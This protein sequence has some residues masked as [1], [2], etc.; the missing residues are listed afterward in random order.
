[1]SL[2]FVSGKIGAGKSYRGMVNIRDEILHG[3]RLIV[4]NLPLKL[5]EFSDYLAEHFPSHDVC[6]Y[7]HWRPATDFECPAGAGVFAPGLVGKMVDGVALVFVPSRIR[8]L[9]DDELKEFYRYRQTGTELVAK[10]NQRAPGDKGPSHPVCLDFSPWGAKGRF[11]GQGVVYHLDECQLFYN[12]RKY[13]EA[14]EEMPFYLSQH[15]KLGDDIYVYTQKPENVDKMLRS[16]T[17]EFIYVTNVGKK[18]IGIFQPPKFFRM[19]AYP[20]VFTGAPGQASEWSRSFRMDLRLADCYETAKGIGIEA[21]KADKEAV[22][23]G[24]SWRWALLLPVLLAALF[25]A[26]GMISKHAVHKFFGQSVDALAAVQHPDK[27]CG[28]RDGG[29]GCARGRK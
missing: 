21:M 17:Q 18:K 7:D 28:R 13:A 16:F 20:D 4:T 3:H 25:P 5:P 10:I 9:G 24:I 15:R 22:A 26:Y 2:Y 11:A 29:A 6:L 12:V 19:A 14:P 1:M 8:I 27:S 23:R